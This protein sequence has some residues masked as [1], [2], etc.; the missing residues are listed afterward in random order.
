MNMIHNMNGGAVI[1]A[2]GKGT[3]MR[4]SRPKALH[5]LLGAPMLALV[6]DS[7]KPLFGPRIWTVLGHGAEEAR[8]ALGGSMGNIV[9]QRQQLGTGHALQSAW[10]ALLDA[11]LDYI[12]VVNGDAPLLETSVL[13]DFISAGLREN[14][15]LAF[16]TLSLASPGAYGRVAR[17]NG[18]VQAVIEAKDY[19]RAVYGPES[20]EVNAGV[21]LLRLAF[22][23]PL[24]GELRQGPGGE[25]YLTDLIG[26]AVEK[27]LR[28]LGLNYGDNSAF[29]GVNTPLEL[30][31]AEELLRARLVR[32]RQEEG[33]L[34]RN[35]GA[36]RLGPG[37]ELEAGVE[38]CG[39][40]E[41]YGQS[42]IAAGARLD[43]HCW[44]KD[45]RIEAGAWVRS[46]CHLEGALL[47]P[48][49]VVGP[50]ARLRP[51]ASLE[52]AAQAG[53]FVELKKARLGCGAKAN[54]LAYLGDAEVGPGV[55]IGAGTI[56][57]NYD[58]CNKH[59][60]SIGEG[61]FIGSNSS[62][63]APVRVG[64]RAVV[65]A[66]SVIT[67]DVPDEALALGRGRQLNHSGRAAA[68]GPKKNH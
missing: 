27:E 1:L 67:E 48:R 51:G 6:L 32:A 7:L 19:D 45:T 20:R 21:Y 26:L 9:L 13:A 17:L 52:E 62:L 4:S 47:G 36:V 24:L 57:C 2:A 66:G 5:E 33:A 34:I 49:C 64:E 8:A 56:T 44:V 30:A 37:V 31:E 23:S 58:G 40:C 43:S 12:L 14:A 11:G 28:V 46:F 29:L 42:R 68:K 61:A 59:F 65:G 60:T 55:N 16:I 3:R 54:H 38:I 15:D 50:F 10:P 63:V 18:E 22:I 53:N 35:A 41:I 25:C 39:P